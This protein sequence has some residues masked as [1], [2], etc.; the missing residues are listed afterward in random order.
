V[1]DHTGPPPAGPLEGEGQGA[2]FQRRRARRFVW[3]RLAPHLASAVAR[4]IV[5]TGRRP[6][7][8]TADRGYGA[9]RVEDDLHE[10][11]VRTVV[12]LREGR[13]GKARQAAEH[14]DRRSRRR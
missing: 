14:T 4:V 5:R 1:S 6:R 7:T 8:V 10:L 11:G 3:A 9:A 12:I 2:P 13:P